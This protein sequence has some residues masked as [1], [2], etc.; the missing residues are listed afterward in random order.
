MSNHNADPSRR[1]RRAGAA[2]V[3]ALTL[4]IAWGCSPKEAA[5]SRSVTQAPFG[6][7]PDGEAVEIYTLENPHGIEVRAMTYGGIIVSLKTPDRSGA[8][9]DI[10]LGYDDLAHYVANSPYF[11]AIIGRYGNRIAKGRFTLDGQTY[12][13]AVNNG[14]NALHGGLKGF[15][16][17]VWKAHSVQTDSTVGVVFQYHSPDGEEGYPGNLDAQ[18]T[19]TLKDDD[20]LVI[21]YYAT[22]DK[23][24]PV[25]LTQHSYFN[26]AGDGSGDVL[27]QELMINADSYT[28]VDSTLIPTGEIAPVEGTPFDFRE[29]TAIGARIA[30]DN[31]QLKNG[32]G[33]DHNFVL[34]RTEADSGKLVHAAE[35][36]DPKTGRT[37]DIYTTEPGIQFY[38][39]NF[40][41]GTIIGKGGH[42]YGHRDAFCLE[43]QHFPDSPNEPSFPSTV[44]RPD[45]EY[46]SETVWK[47]G[48]QR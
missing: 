13:L 22:S 36:V 7:T 16:K 39:G 3:A 15:D 19:Y 6:T 45:Q 20:E 14:P 12:T 24:T 25:N 33:Y 28:P 8:L 17:R 34:N 31:Q 27:G 10:V 43:T 32:G 23:A 30:D 37:L 2:F 18:V 38:S 1:S 11:G 44:L 21:D 46:R 47:F 9:G 48:V 41:D 35:A 40:L 5:M 26:L 29:L 4:L 42:V